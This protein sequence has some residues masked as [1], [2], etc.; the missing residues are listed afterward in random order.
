[1]KKVVK[2][3]K[4]RFKKIKKAVKKRPLISIGATLCALLLIGGLTTLVLVSGGDDDGGSDTSASTTEQS[5][6]G[7][8]D[9]DEQDKVEKSKPKLKEAPPAPVRSGAGT[10]D[11]A[12]REGRLAQAQARGR[13]KN[14]KG[15]SVTVSAAPKQRVTVDY[16]LACYNQSG[17]TSST[18]VSNKRYR[19]T[20]PETRSLPLPIQGAEECTVSVSAQLTRGSGRIKVTVK[21]S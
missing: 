10:L 3:V 18:K 17:K 16:Q 7:G 19:T 12:R 13:V 4:R 1:M 5:D 20:P 14:P 2:S 21:S 9:D 11:V 15:I 8:D 6:D